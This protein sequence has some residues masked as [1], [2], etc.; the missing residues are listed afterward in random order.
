MIPFNQFDMRI[1]ERADGNKKEKASTRRRFEDGNAG[2]RNF[3][4]RGKFSECSIRII[5]LAKFVQIE[6]DRKGGMY[7]IFTNIS[8]KAKIF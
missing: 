3:S 1:I 8:K 6:V 5:P 7:Y 4:V 2:D